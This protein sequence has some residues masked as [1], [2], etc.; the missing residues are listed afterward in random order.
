MHTTKVCYKLKLLL[1]RG[2]QYEMFVKF[3]GK[4]NGTKKHTTY[5]HIKDKNAKDVK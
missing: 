3:V 5:K 1:N 2:M 4:D